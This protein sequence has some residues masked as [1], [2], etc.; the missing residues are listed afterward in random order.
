MALG[1]RSETGKV[2]IGPETTFGT[3]TAAYEYFPTKAMPDTGTLKQV[4]HDAEELT[5]GNYQLPKV[6]GRKSE[7]TLALSYWMHGWKST[8]PT[9]YPTTADV[10][11]DADLLANA[12]G[13]MHH[14]AAATVAT[15]CAAGT[16]ASVINVVAAT[17][18][19]EGAIIVV[20]DT[21]GARWEM[22]AIKSISTLAVTLTAALSFVPTVGA[23]V[24]AGITCFLTDAPQTPTM[25]AKVLTDIFETVQSK[26]MQAVALG[27]RAKSAK[28]TWVAGEFASLDVELA[29]ADWDKTATSATAPAF[30]AYPFPSREAIIGSKAYLTISGTTFCMAASQVETDLGINLLQPRQFCGDVQG[31]GEPTFGTFKPKITLDPLFSTDHLP[32]FTSGAACDLRIQI[33]SQPGKMICIH[34]PN[35]VIIEVPNWANRDGLATQAI[36]LEP[37]LYLGD[38]V[39]TTRDTNALT[40]KDSVLRIAFC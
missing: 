30:A 8:I 28:M 16:T 37:Q 5:V 9:A 39:T 10:H 34:A 31:V 27:C 33:G 19:A 20:Q 18:L 14:A 17:D 36:V 22:A 3:E 12:M 26:Y 15:T 6:L 13:G 11:P 35:A 32:N 40:P 21:V 25:S 1:S 4:V 7:S 29:V 2:L 23:E 24:H 38:G